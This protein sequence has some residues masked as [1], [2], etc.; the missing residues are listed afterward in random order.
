MSDD[1]FRARP[2]AQAIDM[3]CVLT[4]TI[5]HFV[6]RTRSLSTALNRTEPLINAT[7]RN[8]IVSLFSTILQLGR[9]EHGLVF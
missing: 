8:T 3:W 1:N 2:E 7:R 9:G 5:V 6:F 4:L